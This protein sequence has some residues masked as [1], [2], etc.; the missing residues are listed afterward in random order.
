MKIEIDHDGFD[1]VAYFLARDSGEGTAE[2]TE[3]IKE[4]MIAG[5]MMHLRKPGDSLATNGFIVFL[6]SSGTV[7]AAVADHH[8]YCKNHGIK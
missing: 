1:S 8:C 2:G 7:R 6:S 4:R 5:A 3:Q